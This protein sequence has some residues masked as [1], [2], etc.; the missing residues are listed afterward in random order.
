MNDRVS[1]FDDIFILFMKI[2]MESC[3]RLG[4]KHKQ[5]P[6]LGPFSSCIFWQIQTL[7]ELNFFMTQYV[8]VLQIIDMESEKSDVYGRKKTYFF[9]TLN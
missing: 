5:K 7:L 8:V 2:Q 9:A 1:Y 3:S 6:F 4:S